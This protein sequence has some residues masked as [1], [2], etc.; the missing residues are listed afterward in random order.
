MAQI[1]WSEIIKFMQ[2][3]MARSAIAT[4]DGCYVVTGD[5][6]D[7]STPRK[8]VIVKVGDNILWQKSYGGKFIR[9]FRGVTELKDGSLVATGISFYS[10][11][12]GD[13]DVWVVKVDKDGNLLSESTYG[14]KEEQDDGYAV[15]ATSDGGFI[16]CG[17]ALSNNTPSI[18]VLKFTSDCSVMWEKRFPGKY[19]LDIIETTDGGYM[20]SGGSR[21]NGDLN[22]NVYVIKLDAQGNKVW[23][24]VY[25]QQVHVMLHSGI[26]ETMDNGYVVVGKKFVMKIDRNGEVMWNRDYPNSFISSVVE[27]PDGKL[28]A[29]G[30]AIDKHN[31]G[32]A[33][34][35]AM[36]ATGERIWDDCS[37]LPTGWVASVLTNNETYV[38]AGTLPKDMLHNDMFICAFRPTT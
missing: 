31:Y 14:N 25:S 22:S 30:S 11:T 33:Y 10:G 38:A 21:I 9:L 26:T 4:S 27:M 16:V 15:K 8:G 3:Q 17:L 36:N 35:M 34:V 23:D 19:A 32:Y 20:L 28:F 1:A 29:G 7:P 37:F 2:T 5:G 18:W 13:E 12:A 6:Q 24:K